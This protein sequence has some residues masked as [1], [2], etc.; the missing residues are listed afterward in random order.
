MCIG[1]GRVTSSSRDGAV[2]AGA[3]AGR[4]RVPVPVGLLGQTTALPQILKVGA[5]KTGR[6][7]RR[8]RMFDK[9]WRFLH[10]ML[11][12]L[13]SVFAE[14]LVDLRARQHGL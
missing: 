10:G 12:A 8:M 13:V 6:P 11:H 5:H 9:A 2:H 7:L 3:I 14:M 1:D 4:R